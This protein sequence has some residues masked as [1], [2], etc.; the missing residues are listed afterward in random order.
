MGEASLMNVNQAAQDLPCKLP[1][2]VLR[3]SMLGFLIHVRQ[4]RKLHPLH[5]YD[6]EANSVLYE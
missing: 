4:E 1:H 2:L 5:N 3:E 6:F